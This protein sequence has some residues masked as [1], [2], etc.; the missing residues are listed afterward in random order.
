M[1]P[2]MTHKV[3]SDPTRE[4]CTLVRL[5]QA[6][7]KRVQPNFI[8]KCSWNCSADDA[9]PGRKVIKQSRAFQFGLQVIERQR[10]LVRDK[11]AR[12]CALQTRVLAPNAMELV[13]SVLGN[14]GLDVLHVVLIKLGRLAVFEDHKIEVFLSRQRQ[15]GEDLQRRTCYTTYGR[16]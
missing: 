5:R 2:N 12:L 1:Q 6:L 16:Q 14:L 10:E 11:S 4:Q 15:T 3:R 7:Q 13:S 8:Y 9:F